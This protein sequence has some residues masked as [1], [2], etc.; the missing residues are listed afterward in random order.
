MTPYILVWLSGSMILTAIVRGGSP[1]GHV[2]YQLAT[3]LIFVG[4]LMWII[5]TP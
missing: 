1:S 4:S 3:S 2:I 5:F